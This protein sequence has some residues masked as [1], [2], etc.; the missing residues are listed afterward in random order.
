MPCS[1]SKIHFLTSLFLYLITIGNCCSSTS[2]LKCYQTQQTGR[3]GTS[4]NELSAGRKEKDDGN[5]AKLMECPKG[6]DACLKIDLAYT[7]LKGCAK[8]SDVDT[9][10]YDTDTKSSLENVCITDV[11]TELNKLL[12]ETV[13]ADEVFYIKRIC[14]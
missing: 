12:R 11:S 14:N 10:D 1:L 13:S 8:F 4:S 3:N 9:I 5:G 2:T 7:T 6:N